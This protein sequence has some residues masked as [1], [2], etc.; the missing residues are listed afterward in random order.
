MSE[1]KS[2]AA[3][4]RHPNKRWQTT[5]LIIVLAPLLA[6][7]STLRDWMF[8]TPERN[9]NAQVAVPPQDSGV[10]VP[11]LPPQAP[12]RPSPY[13]GAGGQRDGLATVIQEVDAVMRLVDMVS[14]MPAEPADV[15]VNFTRIQAD[16]SAVRAGLV[17]AVLQPR[18][19]PRHWPP[20][21][22]NYREPAR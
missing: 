10:W 13:N 20:L 14:R 15:Q 9:G 6:G 22:G 3:Q 11:L 8:G 19:A 1:R 4:R 18:T 16:L 17:E 2:T 12:L 7:C 21:N 5:I